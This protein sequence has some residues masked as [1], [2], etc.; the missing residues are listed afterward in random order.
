MSVTPAEWANILIGA[1]AL[2]A[3]IITAWSTWQAWKSRKREDKSKLPTVTVVDPVFDGGRDVAVLRFKVDE[4][5]DRIWKVRSVSVKRPAFKRLLHRFENPQY[6]PATH[7]PLY[8]LSGPWRRSVEAVVGIDG[9]SLI[10]VRS[11][12]PRS[13]ELSFNF[14][15]KA[16]PSETSRF[17]ENIRITP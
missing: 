3:S 8:S 13:A 16:S 4:P 15:M 14:V 9:W 2:I 5:H 11:D 17:T 12:E 6:D 10:F 1:G 7:E